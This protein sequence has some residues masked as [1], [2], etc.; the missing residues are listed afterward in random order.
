MDV[1]QANGLY[2]CY[3][4]RHPLTRKGYAESLIQNMQFIEDTYGTYLGSEFGADYGVG[5]GAYVY[6][7]MTLQ[8]TWF[9]SLAEVP[10]SIYYIGDWKNNSRPSIMLGSRTATPDYHRYS[11]NTYTRL[12]LYELVYHDAVV[13]SWRWEDCNHH[14]PEI[15]WKKDL[16]NVLYGNIPLWTLDRERF[17]AFKTTFVES[18][19]KIIPWVHQVCLDEMTE[20]R[21]LTRDHLL[22]MSTFSSGKS[23]IVNFGKEDCRWQEYNIPAE[24]YLIIQ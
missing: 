11:L 5:H 1:Y 21:F 2:E 14:C 23:V 15:W 8:R 6:G 10:G 24:D 3:D 13:T 7:M 17:S 22:Q 4:K 19:R 20:H 9:H 12:P 16:F 18:Y